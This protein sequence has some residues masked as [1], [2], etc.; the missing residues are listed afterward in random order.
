MTLYPALPI[1]AGDDCYRLFFEE[2]ILPVPSEFKPQIILRNGGSDP[3]FFDNLMNP[4]RTLKGF[5]RIEGR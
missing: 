3:H 1:Q 5:R 4:G 2:I